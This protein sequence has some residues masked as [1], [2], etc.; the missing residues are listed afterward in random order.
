MTDENKPENELNGIDEIILKEE[1]IN[2]IK[3][4]YDPE[5]PV[6]IFELGLIYTINLDKLGNVDIQMTLTSPMCPA[7]QSL[8]VDVK[9]KVSAIKGIT[10]VNVEIVWE[11]RWSTSMMSEEARLTLNL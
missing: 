5:I 9:Q 1:I 10:N 2:S 6:N 11:P 7:A 3:T 4:C 8:P